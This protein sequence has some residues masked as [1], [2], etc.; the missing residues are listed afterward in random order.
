MAFSVILCMLYSR[1]NVQYIFHDLISCVLVFDLMKRISFYFTG[2]HH[3][4]K[5]RFCSIFTMPNFMERWTCANS[6]A[7]IVLKVYLIGLAY[8]NKDKFKFFNQVFSFEF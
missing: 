2:H 4:Q 7:K 8:L 5:N 6:I 1:M 3:Q